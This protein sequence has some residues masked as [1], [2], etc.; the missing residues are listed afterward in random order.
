MPIRPNT[1]PSQFNV[2]QPY[3]EG[4][5]CPLAII[6]NNKGEL[7]TVFHSFS[8]LRTASLG[9]APYLLILLVALLA[10]IGASTHGASAHSALAAT[11]R[12]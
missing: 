11:A 2:A 9:C 1:H 12:R 4:S 3:G 6:E 5:R 8:G 7:M 10:G